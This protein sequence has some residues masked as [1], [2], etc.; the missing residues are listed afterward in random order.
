MRF[1]ECL[2]FPRRTLALASGDAERIGRLVPKKVRRNARSPLRRLR[3]EHSARHVPLALA[4]AQ[5]DWRSGRTAFGVQ[6]NE[7][8]DLFHRVPERRRIRQAVV[9]ANEGRE[10]AQRRISEEPGGGTRIT[11]SFRDARKNREARSP[12]WSMS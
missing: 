10:R 11:P 8:A 3:H 1:D 12:T 9:G 2:V 4:L 5:V 7:E 6:R